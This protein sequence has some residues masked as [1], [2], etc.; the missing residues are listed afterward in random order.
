MQIANLEAVSVIGAE[1]GWDNR[2]IEQA[3]ANAIRLCYAERGMHVEADVN[4]EMGTISCRRRN[5]DG[6]RGIWVDIRDPLMPSVKMFMQIIQMQQWGDGAPGRVMEGV[7]TGFRDGGVIYRVAH[8]HVFVPE[9]LLSVMDY[10]TRPELGQ[11]QAISL[12]SSKDEVSGLRMGS[13]RG[14]EFVAAVMECYYPECV[15]GIWMGAS[16]SWAVIRMDPEVMH[17]WLENNGMNLKHLQDV[18]G[19]RRITLIPEG[20]DEDEQKNR[21]SELRHFVNNSW[22]ACR[23]R[24]LTP[25]RV[26]LHTPIDMNDPRKLRTFQ[27]MLEK[28][29]PERDQIIV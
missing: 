11:E 15:S 10:Q 3:L 8:N 16:N 1:Y 20:T 24:E 13:R 29:A 2:T 21:D 19:I 22:R 18:L 9:K 14:H 5:G 25:D 6:E 27:A 23:I 4:M 26:V 12:I 17:E 7:V 28:I